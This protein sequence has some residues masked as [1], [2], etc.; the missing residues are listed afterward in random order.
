MAAGAVLLLTGITNEGLWY[1]ESYTGSHVRQSFSS[2]IHITGGD[3]HPPL[4]YLALRVFTLVFGNTVFTLRLFSVIGA[5][6]L[7]SNRCCW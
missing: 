1:D 3:N 4:Y 7:Q 6:A 2:I 5:R